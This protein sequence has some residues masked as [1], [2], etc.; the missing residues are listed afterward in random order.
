MVEVGV[1][2]GHLSKYMLEQCVVDLNAY[3][4]VDPWKDVGDP[5]HTNAKVSA[6]GETWDT[7]L[8]KVKSLEKRY[9]PVARVMRMTSLAAAKC[10]P[11]ESLD[12]VF[13]D[14]DHRYNMVKADIKAWWPKVRVG[15]IL[16]G[17]DYL[18]ESAANATL[19]RKY[20]GVAR[21][22]DEIFGNQRRLDGNMVW[23]VVREGGI[24]DDQQNGT[25]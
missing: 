19:E 10:F 16:C 3:Y 4:M 21:A 7:I 23:F 2:T 5:L 6:S 11:M 24:D 20:G 8:E 15:G 14:A 18:P 9:Y 13:I 12:L 22:V 17:H 1:W 25:A